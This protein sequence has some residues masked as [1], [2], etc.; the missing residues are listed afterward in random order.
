MVRPRRFRRGFPPRPAE[1]TFTFIAHQGF[2]HLNTRAYVRLLGPCFKT[3]RLKPFRQHPER[4]CGPPPGRAPRPHGTT[5]VPHDRDARGRREP[6]LLARACCVFLGR[7]DGIG[8]R[9]KRPAAARLPC[10]GFSAADAIR[11]M[12]TDMQL[13]CR[14]ARRRSHRRPTPQTEA[15]TAA[16]ATPGRRDSSARRYWRQT[17]PF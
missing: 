17:L 6:S 5:L 2:S 14:L 1:P 8:P 3:G 9:P 13:K 16:R 15:W 10:R 4:V 12:L 11:P 7:T